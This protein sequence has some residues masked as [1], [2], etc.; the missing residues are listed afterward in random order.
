M[1]VPSLVGVAGGNSNL[2]R[3]LS[4]RSSQ[5]NPLTCCRAISIGNSLI[6]LQLDDLLSLNS[7]YNYLFQSRFGLIV[8][9]PLKIKHR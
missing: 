6:Y 2:R 5:L 1:Y 4:A 7:V 8:F 9:P 3:S